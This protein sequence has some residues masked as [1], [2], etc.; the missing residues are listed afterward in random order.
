MSIVW[1]KDGEGFYA[2]A[3]EL[4]GEMRFRVTVENRGSRWNWTVWRPGKYTG[5]LHCGHAVTL[6]GAMWD[7]ERAALRQG[8]RD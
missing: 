3:M 1:E 4:A 7:A 6:H 2:T 5:T 8:C